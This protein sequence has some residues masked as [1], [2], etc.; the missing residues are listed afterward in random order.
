[1]PAQHHG[2]A[3]DGGFVV[4]A[5]AR[6]MTQAPPAVQARLED[7]A[8]YRAAVFAVA[9]SRPGPEALGLTPVTGTLSLARFS[10][11]SPHTLVL[12]I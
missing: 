12:R 11:S 3:A 10:R 5:G 6:C 7:R 8:P 4:A 2:G 1:M 9:A